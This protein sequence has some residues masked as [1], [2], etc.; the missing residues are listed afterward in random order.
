MCPRPPRADTV[1]A[2]RAQMPRKP[3][4]HTRPWTLVDIVNRTIQGRFLLK[5]GPRMN[6]LIIG[7]LARAQ[8][9][10]AV[11]VHCGAFLS[12]HFHL[13]LSCRSVK[14]QAGFMRDFTRK[15]SVESGKLYNWTGST[16]TR[17]YHATEIS[18]EPEA[19]ISR[20]IYCLK[21]GTKENL[22]ASPLDWPGVPI[23]DALISGEPLEGI[24]VDRTAYRAALNQGKKA[25]LD[26]F[27]ERLKLHLDPLPCHRHW[28]RD[29]RRSFVLDLIR[30]IEEET[31][32]RHR[33]NGT[34][35]IGATAVLS[36]DPHDK[37]RKHEP[38]PQPLIHSFSR[39]IWKEMRQALLYIISAYREAADRLKNG[40][41]D[42]QFPEGTFPPARPFVEPSTLK[43]SMA[44]E[45]LQPG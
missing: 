16:F 40:I 39:K 14:D 24:W 22:V 32:A 18:E 41:N 17:R 36:A 35:P 25:T 15:L 9:N 20:L 30:A 43:N 5:P 3:R 37:P 31:L 42:V 7:A 44:P 4:I 2:W 19:Q 29:S 1:Q 23:A 10:H 34:A 45:R 8:E 6:A 38:S 12:G 26:D 21:N 27:T 33:A 28:N 11:R 13:I